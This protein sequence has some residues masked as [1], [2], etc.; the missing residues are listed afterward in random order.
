LATSL[1]AI[2]SRSMAYITRGCRHEPV[3]HS[4]HDAGIVWQARVNPSRRGSFPCTAA[5]VAVVAADRRG[6]RIGCSNR[7]ATGFFFLLLLATAN[8]PPRSEYQQAGHRGSPPRQLQPGLSP[9]S[10]M[11]G[12]AIGGTGSR[13]NGEGRL[14]VAAGPSAPGLRR[15][16]A[17]ARWRA[18]DCRPEA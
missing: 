9:V 1:A 5:D 12:I 2:C 17:V 14:R 8:R 11:C 10:I 18:V 6:M 7:G 3:D 16:L 4:I 13:T 15:R